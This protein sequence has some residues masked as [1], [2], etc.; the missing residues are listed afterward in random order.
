LNVISERRLPLEAGKALT[1]LFVRISKRISQ[2]KLLLAPLIKLRLP[3]AYAPFHLHR[4][5]LRKS[6]ANRRQPESATALLIQK[7]KG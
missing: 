3:M 6:P 7:T 2:P 1:D 4:F 5:K